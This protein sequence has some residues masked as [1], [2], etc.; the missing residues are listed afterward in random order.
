M[1][2]TKIFDINDI[3]N[4]YVLISVNVKMKFHVKIPITE[5]FPEFKKLSKMLG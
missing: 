5:L 1:Q 4:K 2:V 3:N